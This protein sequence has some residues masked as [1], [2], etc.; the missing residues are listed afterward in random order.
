[1][2]GH[3][4]GALGAIW[5]ATGHRDQVR[6]AWIKECWSGLPPYP[7]TPPPPPPYN[8]T[9]FWDT[10]AYFV[11]GPDRIRPTPVESTNINALI[12]RGR[13]KRHWTFLRVEKSRG[14]RNRVFPHS[15][16]QIKRLSDSSL[17]NQPTDQYCANRTN[18]QRKQP[19]FWTNKITQQSMDVLKLSYSAASIYVSNLITVYQIYANYWTIQLCWNTD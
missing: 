10:N 2:R 7:T 19:I 11:R 4:C 12:H 17:D 18:Y 14:E 9:R 15:R 13:K 3:P 1:M 8:H 16:E 5:E 6:W